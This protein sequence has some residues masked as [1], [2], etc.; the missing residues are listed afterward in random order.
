M[1]LSSMSS[2]MKN[3]TLVTEFVLLG[4]TEIRLVEISL[5]VI[6]LSLYLLTLMGNLVII[7]ITLIDQRLQIPMYFFL[8]NLSLM[9][10]GYSSIIIPKMLSKFLTGKGTISLMACFTQCFLYFAVGTSGFFLLTVMSVDRYVAICHPLRYPIIMNRR[11]CIHLVTGSWICG[12]LIILWPSVLLFQLPFCGSNVINHFFC[13]STALIKLSCANTQH[14][15][16]MDFFTAIFTLLGTLSITVVSYVN[17]ISTVSRIP[18][19]T[20]KQKAFSTCASHIIMV[21]ITYGT[22]IFLYL[23]PTRSIGLDFNKM[24]AIFNTILPPLLDPFIY[25]LRNKQ[26]KEALKQAVGRI[27][28]CSKDS[29]M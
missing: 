27:V 28:R 11:V 26:V 7:T 16:L 5:F 9:E 23:K 19:A 8:R 1:P 4:F 12:F 6:I 2:H 24:A 29:R 15:E 14:L 10:I 25:S 20:G 13:D 18:S 22:C 21:S 3:K 17:I